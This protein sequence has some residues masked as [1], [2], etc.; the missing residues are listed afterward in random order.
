MSETRQ[1][2]KST[3]VFAFGTMLSRVTGLL[4]D[5]A[6][7]QIVPATPLA[8]FNIAFRLNNMLRDLLGEGA[9]NAAFI[10]VLSGILE[11]ES[12]TAFREAVSAIFSALLVI[13]GLITVLGIL[14]LPAIFNLLEPIG[15]IAGTKKLSPEYLALMAPLTRWTFPYIFFIGLTVFQMGPLFIM[16]HY[17]TPAWSPALLN[18]AQLAVCGVLFFHPYAFGNPAYGLVAGAWAGG[19]GQFLVQYLAVGILV[20]TWLPNFK[21]RHPAIRASFL[22]WGPVVLGQSAGEVNKLVDM[23]FATSMGPDAVNGLY[24]SNRLVQLP[25]SVFGIA[26]SAAILPS[27]SRSIVRG[28]IGDVRTTLMHGFRQSFFLICPAMVTLFII[29]A[30][31]VALLF[32]RG[33]FTSIN[34]GITGTAT[35]YLAAGLLSFGWVKIAVTGFY[36]AK[37]TRTP[38]TIAFASMLLNI[39]LIFILA[40]RMGFRGLALATT[41]SYTVNF[42]GLYILLCKRYGRLWDRKLLGGLARIALASIAMGVVLYFGYEAIHARFHAETVL[43]RLVSVTASLTLAGCAYVALCQV[44]RVPDTRLFL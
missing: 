37:D 24:F 29:P 33:Y 6:M 9:S 42:I 10:P 3:A 26:I 38:V 34:T 2:S 18:I 13:L 32:Q 5:S 44:M 36:A 16:R 17:S 35:I 14:F 41:L 27:I 20:G 31:I 12:K 28:E 15:L 39:V 8:A 43:H 23:L 40:P 7:G 25:L 21:F 1:L 22:L 4:R 30:P 19:I 11:K